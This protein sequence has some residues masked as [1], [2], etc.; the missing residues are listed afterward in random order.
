M[1]RKLNTS[2]PRRFGFP[3]RYSE[4]DDRTN[5]SENHIRKVS[6]KNNY[7]RIG[8]KKRF[9]KVVNRLRMDDD[10][11]MSNG[12]HSG[13]RKGF[14]NNINNRRNFKN[15]PDTPGVRYQN[16]RP[17][18]RVDSYEV[19]IPYG[20]K[21]EKDNLLKLVQRQIDPHNFTPTSYEVVGNDV[22]F[23]VD[24]IMTANKLQRADR[25]ILL[26]D[27]HYMI[28]RVN[29]RRATPVDSNVKEKMKL[30]M[31]GR[32]IAENKAL[33][34]SGFC[35]DPGFGN[36]IYC[37]LSSPAHLAAAMQII[38]ENIV[39]ILALNL[40]SNGIYTFNENTCNE[41]KKLKNLRIL[42]LGENHLKSVHALNGLQDL[43]IT[44]IILKKNPVCDNYKDPTHFVRYD[45]GIT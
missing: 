23:Y 7:G 13:Q 42:H 34:L 40:N 36:G 3:N 43:E 6:F 15:R 44:E 16:L 32:Y 22:V 1:S 11:D 14:N 24:N 8:K 28:I 39:D 33:N 37:P 17:L 4:H 25:K 18:R 29:E 20:A 10:V 35:K 9:D 38:S 5:N 12:E 19:K 41:F 21:L 27:G 30:V 31:A 45:S 26:H 2:G